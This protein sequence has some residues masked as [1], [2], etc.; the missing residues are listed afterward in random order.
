MLQEHL[1]MANS[2]PDNQA[3]GTGGSK[4]MNSNKNSN[5]DSNRNSNSNRP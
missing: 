4:N 3:G 5:S 1:Q 2:L